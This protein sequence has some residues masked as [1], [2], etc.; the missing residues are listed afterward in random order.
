MLE[1]LPNSGACCS[2]ACLKNY[3]RVRPVKATCLRSFL[4]VGPAVMLH[5]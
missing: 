4:T 2:A 5:A 1:N 3:L